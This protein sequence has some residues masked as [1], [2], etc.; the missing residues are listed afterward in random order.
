MNC[1]PLCVNQDEKFIQVK[2]TPLRSIFKYG[3]IVNLI[4]LY[5]QIGD[6]LP[7]ILTEAGLI[8]TIID[9]IFTICHS[10]SSLPPY[11]PP[12]LQSKP[13]TTLL[14]RWPAVWQMTVGDTETKYS[15][16][17]GWL[18]TNRCACSSQISGVRYM[19]YAKYLNHVVWHT[20]S[21]RF[22][23]VCKLVTAKD[24]GAIFKKIESHVIKTWPVELKGL[25]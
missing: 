16:R 23:N 4:F 5:K 8:F 20:Q 19:V 11:L 15:Q 12:S 21:R 6:L 2:L 25:I 9:L 17:D 24:C 3:Y 7:F 10:I 14:A 22:W 13:Q 1:T 18:K